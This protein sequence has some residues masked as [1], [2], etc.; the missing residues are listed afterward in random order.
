MAKALGRSDLQSVYEYDHEAKSPGELLT[1]SLLRPAQ[2]L[3]KSPIVSLLSLYRVG[4]FSSAMI[5]IQTN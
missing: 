1:Q 4:S 5:D 3:F 2:L